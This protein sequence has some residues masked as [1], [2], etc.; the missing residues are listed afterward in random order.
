VTDRQILQCIGKNI[1]AARLRA[2]ITQ[3]CLAEL[4][5]VHWQT[6]SYIENGRFPCSV[7]I[8][9]RIAFALTTT[10]NRLIDG[11]PEPDQARMDEIK[12]TLARKRKPAG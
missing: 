2:G 7:T 1:R 5:E 9:T 3:E 8:F 6:I 10:P 11:L 4:V 12:K